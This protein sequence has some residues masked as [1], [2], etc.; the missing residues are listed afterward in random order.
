MGSD[1]V[2]LLPR[3]DTV[4]VLVGADPQADGAMVSDAGGRPPAPSLRD[5][6]DAA[7][8]GLLDS[9]GFG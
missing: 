1:D 2:V 6:V 5:R 3:G 7:A 9:F 4:V 8:R